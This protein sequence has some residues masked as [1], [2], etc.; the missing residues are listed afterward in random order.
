MHTDQDNNFTIVIPTY[1]EAKNIPDLLKRIAS[2]NF[3]NRSF[4]VLLVDD[5]S[6]D[7]TEEIVDQLS[8]VYP[9]VRVIVRS[10]ERNL[11]ESVIDGFKNAQYPIVVTMDA[12]LSHPPEKIPEMLAVLAEPGVDIVIGSRYVAG[13]ST[14]YYWPRSRKAA[15]WLAALIARYLLSANAKDPLSGFLAIRKKTFFSAEQLNPIGWKIGLEIMI[16]CHCKN[17]REVPIHFAQRRYGSSKL[18]FRISID[19]LTHVFRLMSYK[20]IHLNS[21]GNKTQ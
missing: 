9:W 14:D 18:N 16:K 7:G 20:L 1:R 13:G 10:N 4:E 2:V 3:H 21:D 5:N 17:I 12:D 11:S 19:Y 15:S 6:Q 8:T